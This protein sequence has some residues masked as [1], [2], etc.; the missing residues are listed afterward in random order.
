[1]LLYE[2]LTGAAPF[3]G[4]TERARYARILSAA[5]E[6]PDHV[7]ASAQAAIRALCAPEATA[8]LGM[9]GDGAEEIKAHWFFKSLDWDAVEGRRGEPPFLPTV[10]SNDEWAAVAP[11]CV[12]EEPAANKPEVDALFDGY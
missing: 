11:I 6:F 1:M 2:M 9:G 10:R 8:R 5:F 4:D 7:E 12:P 3:P